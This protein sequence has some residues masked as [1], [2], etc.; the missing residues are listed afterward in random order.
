MASDGEF[1]RAFEEKRWPLEKW[2]HRD[3]VRLAYLYLR[4]YPFG[5]AADRIREGIKAHN[6]AHGVVEGPTS[7]YHETM[8]IAWLRLVEMVLAEYGAEETGEKFCD[9]HPELMEK[10]ILR[11][12]YSKDLF[13][14]ARAK[15]EFV[16][17]DLGALPRRRGRAG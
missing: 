6:A 10:K 16:E 5:E 4:A 17:P 2:H 8:T 9:A 7:G 12:Y 1:L 14:S 11:L 15:G 3:H 13:M